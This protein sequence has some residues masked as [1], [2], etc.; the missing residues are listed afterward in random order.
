MASANQVYFQRSMELGA[1]ANVLHFHSVALHQKIRFEDWFRRYGNDDEH[2][3]KSKCFLNDIDCVVN[4]NEINMASTLPTLWWRFISPHSER[5]LLSFYTNTFW[6]SLSQTQ[7]NANTQTHTHTWR[8]IKSSTVVCSPIRSSQFASA[9]TISFFPLLFFIASHMTVRFASCFFVCM[10]AGA[11]WIF[12][13]RNCRLSCSRL[14]FV[15][16][17]IYGY[18]RTLMNARL[19]EM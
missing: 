11:E 12:Y 2:R 7:T 3:T 14:C 1:F 16:I 9:A 15:S 4:R 19:W 18:A 10:A 5:I 13:S 6:I 17:T 8:I